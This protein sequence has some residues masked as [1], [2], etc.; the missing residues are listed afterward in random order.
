MYVVWVGFSRWPIECCRFSQ[1]WS[2]PPM[3]THHLIWHWV[4]D[5]LLVILPASHDPCFWL[6]VCLLICVQRQ[7]CL[8]PLALHLGMKY[9]Q[10][11][12]ALILTCEWA[13]LCQASWLRHTNLPQCLQRIK[14][15]VFITWPPFLLFFFSFIR[16]INFI[17]NQ[18]LERMLKINV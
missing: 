1:L 15:T 7:F 14:H 2:L 10:K 16:L 17:L 18:F 8:H 5:T 6:V 4:R 12:P 9:L 3:W 11:G 13:W